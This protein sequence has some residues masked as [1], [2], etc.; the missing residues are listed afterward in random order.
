MLWPQVLYTAVARVEVGVAKKA[1]VA[2]VK[3]ARAEVVVA[4][5]YL[6]P[7]P[8]SAYCYMSYTVLLPTAHIRLPSTIVRVPS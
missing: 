7:A 2:V 3:A 8:V 4:L 1:G 5:S 6:L